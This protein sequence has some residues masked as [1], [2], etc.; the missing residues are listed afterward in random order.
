MTGRAEDDVRLAVLDL[1]SAGLGNTAI[2][3]RLGI[4][5]GR[6]AGILRAV[7]EAE[8]EAYSAAC[9]AG[10]GHLWA[11]GDVRPAPWVAA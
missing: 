10:E 3:R 2:A 11:T 6:V 8:A 9:A 4:G 7:R 1:K 5:C